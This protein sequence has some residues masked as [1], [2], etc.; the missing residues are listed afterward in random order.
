M[1]EERALSLTE[2]PR[3]SACPLPPFGG[4]LAKLRLNHP[5][6]RWA[7]APSPE[8]RFSDGEARAAGSMLS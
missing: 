7:D 5:G 4:G 6:L 3:M 1:P 8:I 2:R